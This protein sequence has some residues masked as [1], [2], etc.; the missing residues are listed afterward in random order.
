[1]RDTAAPRI[2]S[3]LAMFVSRTAGGLRWCAGIALTAV[4]AACG[5]GGG[6]GEPL[7]DVEARKPSCIGYDHVYITVQRVRVLQ[8]VGGVEQWTEVALTAPR[9]IDLMNSGGLLQ[10]L[11]A[12][13]L[14]VG[15]YTEV[16]LIVAAGDDASLANAA[17]PIGGGEAALNVPSGAQDGLKLIG[18]FV[19]PMGQTGDVVLSGFD[20]CQ[21]VTQTGNS[22]KYNLKPELSASVQLAGAAAETRIASG[23]VTAVIGGGYV[24][25]RQESS[26]VHA[27]Q[28][29][30]ADGQPVGSETI[31]AL[32]LDPADIFGP[33][34]TG[35]APLTGGGYA[36]VWIKLVTFGRD[37]DINQVFTQSFTP[38]GAPIGSP[39]PIA[40][41]FFARLLN[42][43]RAFPR[44][45][46]LTGGGYAVVWTGQTADDFG[47]V[48]VQ[49]FNADGTP[50]G[51]PQNVSPFGRGHLGIT[52]LVTGGY[53]VTWSDVSEGGVRAYSSTD[54]PLGPVQ[55]AGISWG[56]PED[57]G[58][59]VTAPLAGG[60]AILVW[61]WWNLATA[62]MQQLAADGTPLASWRPVD[63]SIPGF[64]SHSA[65]SAAGLPDGGYVVAWIDAGQVHA[66]RF[67]ADG[68]PAGAETRINLV[69]TLPQGPTTVVPM[70]GGGFMIAWSGVGADGTRAN[71]GRLFS[72]SG[73]LGTP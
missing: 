37:F 28:R 11:G 62:F 59:G 35:V 8:Q 70:A 57:T 4:L 44:V 36:V 24:V 13:P 45:A 73:L 49:R 40:Q 71:Y 56:G 32:P 47:G 17:Q 43:P 31:I 34:M 9:R 21:A 48:R 72:A 50:A 15:H 5:G 20:A 6:S 63:G 60:G 10:A 46:A 41:V 14:A 1:M 23:S 69:T 7:A 19:V 65:P 26:N 38:A 55:T 29:Y 27:L 2:A 12:A 58:P 18:D 42:Q 68:T 61:R 67:A 64:G 33:R 3:L 54:V 16:R 25:S 51:A 22:G 39:A 30:G 52:G 66:L 53:L